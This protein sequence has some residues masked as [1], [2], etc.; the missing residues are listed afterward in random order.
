[1][2]GESSLWLL[3]WRLEGKVLVVVKGGGRK[4]E[5]LADAEGAAGEDMM[6]IYSDGWMR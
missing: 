2:R 3:L 4:G 5:W 1:M 6:F